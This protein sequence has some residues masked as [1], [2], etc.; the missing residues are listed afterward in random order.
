MIATDLRAAIGSLGLRSAIGREPVVID[1]DQGPHV[2]AL[3]RNQRILGVFVSAIEAGQVIADEAI[4]HA[5]HAAHD[6]AM[7]Q[8][9]RAEIQ[10]LTVSRLFR[11]AG[12][13]HRFLKGVAL[14]HTSIM[15]PSERSFRDVDV[16][17]RGSQVARA[18]AVIEASG[19]VRKH[20][21]LAR[22]Y[23]QRFGKSVTME[24]NNVEIDLYRLL[25][26]GPFG[27]W[28]HPDDLFV[29]PDDVTIAGQLLPT[30]DRTDHLLHACYHA[31]LGQAE[32]V[33]A[34]LR[35]IVLL[36]G[37]GSRVDGERLARTVR[38]WRGTAVIDRAVSL[39]HKS[40]TV[41]LP[42]IVTHISRHNIAHDEVSMISPYLTT[43]PRGRFA[44]LA[45]ATLRA[46]DPRDRAAYAIAVGAA[47][48]GRSLRRIGSALLGR[49]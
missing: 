41:E 30:L 39:V 44:A 37:D 19:G 31:A 48:N 20:A 15:S 40:L 28:M 34:N 22:G 45:P 12:V 1:E 6:E 8:S 38:R 13:E 47:N 16:L 7:A 36:A 25:C 27:V 26:P 29:L 43:S 3:L 2:L 11:Q 4:G 14:A 21:E 49:S 24:F 35:D 32:P 9:M 18:V 10:A 17:V 23:D 5:V 42:E 46:L 33:L